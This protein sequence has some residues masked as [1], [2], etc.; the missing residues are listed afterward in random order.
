M[1]D[2]A[3]EE[4][5]PCIFDEIRRFWKTDIESHDTRYFQAHFGGWKNGG[6]GIINEC[7]KW[8]VE[9]IFRDLCHSIS[10]EGCFGFY[11][12]IEWE[13]GADE[14]LL[15]IYSIPQQRVLFTPRFID[16]DF[17]ED[18]KFK[19]ELYHEGFG[20]NIEQIIDES[21]TPI[22]PSKY[23]YLFEKRNYFATSIK[24]ADG[25]DMLWGAVDKQG[26]EIVPCKYSATW[27]GLSI[28][29]G[30]VIFK[31][32]EKLG[33][34]TFDN[35][36][37]I[38]PSYT[39]LRNLDGYLLFEAKQGG[40]PDLIDKGLLGLLAKDGEIALPFQYERISFHHNLI[41]AKDDSGST[42]F[43][44]IRKQALAPS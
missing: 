19:V 31:K 44:Y 33:L 38:D 23:T 11:D 17:R 29:S 10:E 40:S 5:I 25:D 42:L 20:R 43:S 36:I 28:D 27:D 26:N 22:W 37:I 12:K 21:G 39:G 34:M 15:G 16:V 9:P 32:N 1:I 13:D 41:I 35:E 8:V 7:G 4:V 3:G 24:S 2:K 18:G 30:R 6:W 14:R